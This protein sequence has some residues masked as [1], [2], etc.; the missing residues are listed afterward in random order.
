M[1]KFNGLGVILALIG[2]VSCVLVNGIASSKAVSIGGEAGAGVISEDPAQFGKILILQL[3]PGSQGIYGLLIGFI[4]LSNIGIIGAPAEVSLAKGILYLCATLPMTIVGY[5][6]AIR[7]CKAGVASMAVVQKRP[8]E[9]G[10]AM[11]FPAM[12]ETYA[13]LA[14]LISILA[15]SGVANLVI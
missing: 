3:L 2:A 10:K 5:T 9:F 13:I 8:D 6:S 1:D 7:Q 11:I 14:L 12:V 4:T 15:V